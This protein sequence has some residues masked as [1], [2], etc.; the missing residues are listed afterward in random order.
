MIT[1]SAIAFGWNM[2]CMFCS[3]FLFC[4]AVLV[5]IQNQFMGGGKK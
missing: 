1:I 3:G 5:W 2:F 4:L